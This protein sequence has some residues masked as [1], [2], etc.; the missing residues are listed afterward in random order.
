M[1]F[2]LLGMVP[3][4]LLVQFISN[5]DRITYLLFIFKDIK[6]AAQLANVFQKFTNGSE[7]Y[8]SKSFKLTLMHNLP[9]R[10]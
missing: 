1:A 6:L 7:G 3:W 10:L 2:F 4:N 5:F 8:F 9:T